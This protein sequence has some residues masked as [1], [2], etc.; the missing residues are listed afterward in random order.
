MVEKVD[1]FGIF[2]YFLFLLFFH[3]FDS[4]PALEKSNALFWNTLS[5]QSQCHLGFGNTHHYKNTH[6]NMDVNIFRT[7]KN[8]NATF[9]CNWILKNFF[10]SFSLKAPGMWKI[11]KIH[12]F[13]CK[14]F[15]FL[16]TIPIS[17]NYS[18]FKPNANLPRIN[19]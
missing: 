11:F 3:S 2:C 14:S 12:F 4:V 8:L 13:S 10:G 18:I 7:L 6:K 16:S 5:F 9:V 17:H 1:F 15:V 19:Y